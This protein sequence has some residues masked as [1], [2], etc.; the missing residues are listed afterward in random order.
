MTEGERIMA[1]AVP[2]PG[3]YQNLAFA[4]YLALDCASASRLSDMRKSAAR[5]RWNID[6]PDSEQTPALLLGSAIHCSVLERDR[7]YERY[8]LRF[9]GDGR[10]K[11]VREVRERQTARGIIGLSEEQMDAIAGV[12]LAVANHELA[13]PLLKLPEA[14]REISVVW[15][16]VTTSGFPVYCKI[17]PD[18][19]DAASR[20]CV[21]LKTSLHADPM[22]FPR[23]IHTYGY[24]RAAA[25]YMRGLAEAG[26]AC[27]AYLF[28]AV[29]KDPPFECALYTLEAAALE[30]GQAEYRALLDRYGKCCTKNEWPGYPGG[31]LPIGLPVWAYRQ[32][33]EEVVNA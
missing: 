16:D 4:D 6:H 32:I 31:V 17:R 28:L 26:L 10:T 29:E 22:N 9:P 5:C 25:F 33:N 15:Q 12:T 2:K 19:Y 23:E 8:A 20:V 30:A 11:A 18:F 13:G 24:H 1:T 14:L 7:F 27:D 3:V 21:D